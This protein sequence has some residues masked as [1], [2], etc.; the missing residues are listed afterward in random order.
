MKTD[1]QHLLPAH[2]PF[3]RRRLF[4]GVIFSIFFIFS[5]IL[6]IGFLD[7]NGGDYTR[8]FNQIFSSIHTAYGAGIFRYISYL[9]I[10]SKGYYLGSAIYFILISFLTYNTFHRPTVVL[11]YPII[12]SILYITGVIP[13][14]FLSTF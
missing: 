11:W 2:L 13:L 14:L 1:P 4:W 7:K 12:L 8:T 3:Y 5:T 9:I 6:L 10:G